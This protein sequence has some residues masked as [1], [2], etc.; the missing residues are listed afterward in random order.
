[1]LSPAD[2]RVYATKRCPSWC[3]R[4]LM[5]ARARALVEAA[6]SPPAYGSTAAT[7][8]VLND[9]DAVHLAF[10]AGGQRGSGA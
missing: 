1:M 2:E 9:H 4:V 8:P 10:E 7:R 3:D 6:P 5:D